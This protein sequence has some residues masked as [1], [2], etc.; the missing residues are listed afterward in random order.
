M[1][2]KHLSVFLKI[3]N[4]A[5][6][7]GFFIFK[8]SKS[9]AY[10][11]DFLTMYFYPSNLKS[12]IKKSPWTL[13][14]Q[15]PGARNMSCFYCGEEGSKACPDCQVRWGQLTS[16]HCTSSVIDVSHCHES[17]SQVTVMSLVLLSGV[18]VMIHCH[19]SLSQVAVM[20]HGQKSL[21]QFTV[22]NHC[23]ESR[24]QVIAT[25]QIQESLS[26]VTILNHCHKSHCHNSLKQ[27]TV[28]SYCNKLMPQVT[29]Q[30]D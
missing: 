18:T 11:F 12:W 26:W 30:S 6:L 1:E 28:R 4:R 15:T 20:S 5:F 10:T 19:E 16:S 14:F 3:L 17:L 27:V 21:S 2:I 25:I 22:R 23:Q 29:I 8:L 7:L 9:K 24:S 13:P